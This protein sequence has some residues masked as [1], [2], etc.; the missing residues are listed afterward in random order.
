MKAFILAAGI[1]SRLRPI[2]DEVPK[3]MVKVGDETIIERQLKSLVGAGINEIYVCTGYKNDVLEGFVK[4]K[5]PFVK[6]QINILGT[7]RIRCFR[8]QIV[9]GSTAAKR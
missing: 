7:N 6:F 2:T 9:V 1:G 8:R 3:C 4:E 5:Y